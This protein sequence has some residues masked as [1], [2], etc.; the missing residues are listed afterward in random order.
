MKNIFISYGREDLA[1]VE[2]EIIPK[3]KSING[4][5][6]WF[7]FECIETG[8]DSFSEEINKGIENSF[9]FIIVLSKKTMNKD[10]PFKEFTTQEELRQKDS[11][12]KT[13]ILKLD[14]SEFAGHFAEYKDKEKDIISWNKPREVEKMEKDIKRWIKEKA[15]SYFNEGKSL[16]NKDFK[17]A[18]N[19][20]MLAAE[21]GNSEALSKVAYYYHTGKNDVENNPQKALE[22]CKKAYDLGSIGAESLMASIYLKIGNTDK[23]QKY[24]NDSADKG[25]AYSQYRLGKEYKEGKIYKKDIIMAICWLKKATENIDNPIPDAWLLL[26]DIM[27]DK[28]IDEKDKA[29]DCYQR[30]KEGFIIYKKD[31]E[32]EDY[33][34]KRINDIEERLDKIHSTQG[35]YNILHKA[36]S[37]NNS[38]R[39]HDKGTPSRSG[40]SPRTHKKR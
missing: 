7:D 20:Y 4:A 9:I 11:S 13:V 17:K 5:D 34:I 3:I 1:I 33:A 6:C 10:W 39:P 22:W 35:R 30:A 36:N 31:P 32:K 12:R 29:I 18:F 15:N 21:M 40:Q 8:A 19:L 23:F 28:C 16:A 14:K 2:E 37:S 38:R 24:L 27:K 26:G 25:W